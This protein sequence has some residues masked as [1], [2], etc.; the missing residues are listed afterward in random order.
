MDIVYIRD[1]YIDTI[2]GVFD[3]EREVKQRLVFD[4]EMATDIRRASQTDNLDFALDYYG[5]SNRVTQFVEQSRCLLVER[6]AEEV[7]ALIMSE[8]SVPWLKLRLGKPGAVKNARDVGLVIER[9]VK[10]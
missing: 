1:L 5:I 8:F 6:L 7:A 9:G 3:W 2:I 10:P 4:L